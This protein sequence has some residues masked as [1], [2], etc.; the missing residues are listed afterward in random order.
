MLGI[1]VILLVSG[2]LLYWLDKEQFQALGSLQLGKQML[3]FSVGLGFFLL[4]HLLMKGLDTISQSISW[5]INPDFNYQL[6]LSTLWYQFKSVL[7]EELIF[8][9]VLLYFLIKRLGWQAALIISAIAFGV[10][11]WFSYGLWGALVP[12]IYIFLITGAMG[13]VWA[14]AFAR[15]RS[16]MLGLGMHLGWNLIAAFFSTGPNGEVLFIEQSRV[17]FSEWNNLWYLLAQ[18]LA[19]PIITILLLRY[20]WPPHSSSATPPSALSD[21]ES[22]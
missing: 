18:G 5:R 2:G 8:R 14:W 15:T 9:G 13:Y 4:F 11:H 19:V 12:M 21:F 20:L 22:D 3:Q 1:V 7:T 17:A 6:A 16:I 10:Y